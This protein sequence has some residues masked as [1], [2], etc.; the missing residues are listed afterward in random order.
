[1]TPHL[2]DTLKELRTNQKKLALKCGR[3]L[4]EWVFANKRGN[5]FDSMT[6]KNALNQCL[7]AVG[8]RRIR[9]HDLRD[10]SLDERT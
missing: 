10:N 3:P 6:F 7:K 4:P 8:L 2:T 5:I 1:M 9:I